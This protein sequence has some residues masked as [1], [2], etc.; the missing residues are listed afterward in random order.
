VL[1]KAEDEGVPVRSATLPIDVTVLRD[2]G[3]LQFSN[4][5]YKTQISENKAINSIVYTVA[6]APGVSTLNWLQ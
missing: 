4:E 5:V 6:A 2:D 1:V 3:E